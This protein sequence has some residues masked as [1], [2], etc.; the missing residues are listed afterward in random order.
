M[1]KTE[2]EIVRGIC[3]Y[4]Q[5]ETLD[6]V[7]EVIEAVLTMSD[8]WLQ[9]NGIELR[10]IAREDIEETY[11]ESIVELIKECYLGN[12]E[13]P[14]WIA[15]DWNKTVENTMTDGYGMHFSSYD[16]SEHETENYHYFRIG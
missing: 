12:V 6:E 2:K 3:D 9:C 16:H 5:F 8:E 15:I 10:V 13:I 11:H 1:N 4:Q 7:K 14:A